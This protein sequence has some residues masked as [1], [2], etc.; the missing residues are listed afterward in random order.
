MICL[1]AIT[2]QFLWELKLKDGSPRRGMIYKK[3]NKKND[4]K[5][6]F[7]SYKKL[8]SVNVKDGKI[9]KNFGKNGIVKLKKPSLTSPAIFENNLIITTS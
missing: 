6:F 2:G 1:D 9:N 5:I 8:I 7:S 4:S 3:K